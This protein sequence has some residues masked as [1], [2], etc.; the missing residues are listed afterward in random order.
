MRHMEN[1][2]PVPRGTET[3]MIS[4]NYK[5]VVALPYAAAKM[6]EALPIHTIQRAA[7][8]VDSAS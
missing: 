1:P 8:A 5:F 3:S 7:T 4:Y 6:V 2:K